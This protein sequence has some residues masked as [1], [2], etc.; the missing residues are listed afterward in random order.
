MSKLNQRQIA[1]LCLEHLDN[2]I[3]LLQQFIDTSDTINQRIGLSTPDQPSTKELFHSISENAGQLAMART[4]LQ[5]QMAAWLGRPGR[6][7]TVREL[8]AAL[9]AELAEPIETR[10]R[11]LLELESAIRS[12]NRTNSFL[13]QQSF[14]LY[15]RIVAGLAGEAPSAPVYS[16]KGIVGDL[17]T[18]NLLKTD[19]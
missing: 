6:K 3:T 5:N 14:D 7:V 11:Q 10:R 17:P 18:G 16:P 2:E 4:T 1:Q 15:Q 13:I 8:A 12:M 19:C 9:P